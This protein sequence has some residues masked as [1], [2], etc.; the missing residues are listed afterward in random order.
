MLPGLSDRLLEEEIFEPMDISLFQFSS[1]GSVSVPQLERL[2]SRPAVG[3]LHDSAGSRASSKAG[4]QDSANLDVLRSFAV[5]LV[6]GFHLAKFFDWRLARMRVTDFGLLG[7]MFFFVHT[8]LV[9]MFSLERQR[10]AAAGPLFLPFMVRRCFRIYPLAILT[11]TFVYFFHIPSDLQVGGF[12]L[13]QQSAGNLLAN[14]LLVQNVT[15][16]PANPGVLWSLP[17]E[18]QMYLALPALFILAIRTKVWWAMAALW[19]AVVA[20]WLA[21]GHFAG[22]LPL[23]ETGIRSP[24]EALLKFTRFVPC[25]LPGLVAYKL[26]HRPRIFPAAAWLPF[27]G[28]CCAAF[29]YW[30]GGTPVQFGWLICLAIGVGAALFREMPANWFARLAKRIARYSYGIYLLHYFAIWLAFDV[31]RERAAWTRI[32]VFTVVLT[33]LPALLYHTVEAPMIGVGARLSR[34]SCRWQLATAMLVLILSISLAGASSARAQ[35]LANRVAPSSA[36]SRTPEDLNQRLQKAVEELSGRADA[37]SREST[38]GPD[39]LLNI[40]VFEA[41]ELNCTARVTAGGEISMQLLG[42]IHA[43]GLTPRELETSL[44]GRLERTYLKNPHVGVF[45]QEL[46]SHAVSV[47]G[48]VKS[49]GVFQIRGSKSLIEMLSLA[50]GLADDAGDVALIMRSAS[51]QPATSKPGEAI[52]AYRPATVFPSFEPSSSEYSTAK[53][54]SIDQSALAAPANLGEFVEINLKKLLESPDAALNVLIHPG[55]IVK[56]PRA[57]IVYVVGEV[58]KPGGFVLQNNESISVLQALALAQGPTHTSAIGHTRIIRT[59]PVTG[60]RTEIPANL[61]RIFSG[62]APDTFLQAKDVVFVPNSATKSVLYR[63]SEAAL[64]TAAGVAIYKW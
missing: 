5:L 36:P 17:L 28:V 46:Q 29:L 27:L 9:L 11:V 39:D 58:V 4:A 32:V 60:A 31:F 40:T 13:L 3:Y 44:E 61:G 26:W 30:S 49:P 8:T 12:H 18:L 47:M 56:V 55:D 23:S 20:V 63:S 6:V 59:D 64:Q 19:A 21:I 2:A 43:G 25:F 10:A 41:P 24:W 54:S 14:I 15:R 34:A 37:Y 57:G 33:A 38:I 53:V 48:A 16:Q 45:V 35:T 51:D 7:V 50:Q 1:V 42:A 62:K 52:P 22:V